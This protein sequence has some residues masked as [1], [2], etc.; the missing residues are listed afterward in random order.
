MVWTPL[1]LGKE[2]LARMERLEQFRVSVYGKAAA[3]IAPNLD[4]V[5]AADVVKAM[6]NLEF[7][8]SMERIDSES[9]EPAPKARKGL[10]NLAKKADDLAEAIKGLGCGAVAVMQRH[11]VRTD[12][13]RDARPDLLP[14]NNP[15]YSPQSDEEAEVWMA[16]GGWVIRLRALAELARVKAAR[17]ACQGAKGG[18][19]SFAARLGQDAPEEW[20]ARACNGYLRANG[21]DSQAVS[22]KM[23]RA[24]LE[25]DNGKK[26]TSPHTGRKAVRKVAQTKLKSVTV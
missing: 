18:R 5:N 10:L 17:I 26:L 20:L 13:Y 19:I 21:C 3:L 2:S 11:T 8:F 14:E 4:G 12:L 24:I 7:S 16:G 22:L 25:A 9:V 1:K 23:V 6:E 15:R